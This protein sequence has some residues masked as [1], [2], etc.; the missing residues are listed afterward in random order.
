M[1]KAKSPFNQ[2]ESIAELAKTNRDLISCYECP[3]CFNYAHPPLRPCVNGH[4]FCDSCRSRLDRC[5]VCR[6]EKSPA[7][8]W[9]L[10]AVHDKLYFPCRRSCRKMVRGDLLWDHEQRCPARK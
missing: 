6:Q 4:I 2:S 3:V 10:E 5:P 9:V 7:R 8:D 1:E